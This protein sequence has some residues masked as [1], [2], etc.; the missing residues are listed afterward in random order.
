MIKYDQ[1]QEK[2]DIKHL[3]DQQQAEVISQKFAQ[4]ANEYEPLN[5]DKIQIPTFTKEDIPNISESDVLEALDN[6]KMNKS[7]R[8]TDVP[9]R[10]YKYFSKYLCKPLSYLIN[11]AIVLGCWPKFLKLEVV[12]AVPKVPQPKNIDDLRNISGLMNL[13][14]IM[15]KVICKL[16]IE[17]MK[18]SLDPAQYANQK[19]ISTQHYL[20]KMLDRILSALDNNSKGE[21]IAVLTT[22]IDWKSA[23]PR[24]CS[25]L[26]IQSFIK[27][28]VRSSLIPI[29]ISFFEDRRMYVRWHGVTSETRKLNAGGPQGSTLGILEY[30]SQSNDNADNVPLEDR[31]KFVDDLS[32]LEVIHLLTVGLASV[33][34]R[35]TV[36]SNVA[37]HNQIIPAENLKTQ[38]YVT[39]IN[40]WTEKKMMLLNPKKT[41]IMIF[42][43]TEKQ[44]TTDIRIK[45]ETLQT[46]SEAKLLGVHMTDDLKWHRNTEVI[47]K[48]ANKRMLLL[49]KASKFTSQI[50]DLTTIYK[51]FIRSILENSCVVWHSS[52]T[53]QDS[54]AIERVQKAACKIILKEFYE[55][56]DNALKS[57]RLEKLKDRRE[58]LCL[59]FAKKCLR[60]E[61][62]KSMFP[63]NRNKRSLRN[64]N[65]YL[66]KL[67]ATE[68]YRKS[69]I[70]HMQ[71]LLNEHEKV[72]A[73][74]VRFKGL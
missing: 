55:G 7:E 61:K 16:I 12:T 19:G 70:P 71:N 57:L 26:G 31:F 59:S 45:D 63:L 28:G 60:N 4:I 50:S 3:S 13:N 44:F 68:R 47:V 24:Q 40:E 58:S 22:M 35:R 36:P 65:N 14:K 5:R 27:N 74:L 72:K 53:E 2:I 38:K 43:T 54:E 6:L 67:A 41:K 69:A 48:K 25:T 29:L 11:K 42:N 23:F 34:I 21:C 49:S 52:L 32:I 66:V 8:P 20:I 17:D 15:E 73:K 46:V 62:L 51:I 64:Q 18:S 9:A 30:L 39:E 37:G 56:Y 10:I 1:K 33:N